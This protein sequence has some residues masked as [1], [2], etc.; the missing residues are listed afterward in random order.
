M[1]VR[2]EPTFIVP[3][4]IYTATPEGSNHVPSLL[5]IPERWHVKTSNT[6]IQAIAKDYSAAS[7]DSP[8]KI[9][10]IWPCFALIRH[11]SN[12]RK[13][14]TLFRRIMSIAIRLLSLFDV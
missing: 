12:L 8:A 6:E 5:A 9:Y 2:E 13:Q 4:S 1:K 11:V 3:D 10:A 7:P 14:P